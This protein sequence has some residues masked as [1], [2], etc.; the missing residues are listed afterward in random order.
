MRGAFSGQQVSRNHSSHRNYS[1]INGTASSNGTG[2]IGK[3]SDGDRLESGR[4]TAIERVGVSISN[5]PAVPNGMELPGGWTVTPGSPARCGGRFRDRFGNG[6]QSPVPWFPQALPACLPAGPSDGLGHRGLVPVSGTVVSE[7]VGS[8]TA[9]AF[10]S[11]PPEAVCFFSRAGG[12]PTA[13]WRW[14][15]P[16]WRCLLGPG[17]CTGRTGCS[18]R[19]RSRP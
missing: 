13:G 3:R 2:G 5:L 11:P 1:I 10:R 16:A 17:C 18:P 15:G 9:E 12:E 6:D 8:R 7:R 14:P 19:R 4:D